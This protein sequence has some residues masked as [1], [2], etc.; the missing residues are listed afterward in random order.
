MKLHRQFV[1]DDE[2]FY[3]TCLTHTFDDRFEATVEQL[4][5]SVSMELESKTYAWHRCRR[6]SF[7][8]QWEV[9]SS[10]L[11]EIT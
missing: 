5:Y 4:Y 8:W 11:H 7:S 3:A 1:Y 6:K 10:N 9:E 2:K